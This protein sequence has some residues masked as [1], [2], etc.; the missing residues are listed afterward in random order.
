MIHVPA[1]TPAATGKNKG[2]VQ[3][4]TW[5]TAIKPEDNATGLPVHKDKVSVVVSGDSLT[6][7]QFESY[8]EIRSVAGDQYER[9]ALE[10]FNAKL[11]AAQLNTARGKTGKLTIA[12][13][14]V[15]E[16]VR[17]VISAFDVASLFAPPAAKA[18]K[19][20]RGV[21][22]ELAN[23]TAAAESMSKEDLLAAIAALANKTK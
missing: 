21:R 3:S 19:A 1:A 16:Y 5:P 14:N 11:S 2:K 17:G 13:L 9:T 8:D 7:A 12:P 23:L 18:E 4:Y 22:A 15:I 20:S 6:V 10:L